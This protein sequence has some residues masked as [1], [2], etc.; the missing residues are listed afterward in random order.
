VAI[1]VGAAATASAAG[2]LYHNEAA[3]IAAFELPRG[4][5]QAA[6]VGY[7]RV[8]LVATGPEG[9]QLVLS[10]QPV[11][12]GTGAVVLAQRAAAALTAQGFASPRVVPDESERARL[13]ATLDG[14]RRVLRQLYAV[15]GDQAVVVTLVA[16][17]GQTAVLRAFERS[18]ETLEIG[19]PD[20]R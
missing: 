10:S 15:D 13:E 20:A 4:F 2:R 16:P 14:G 17:V 1:L 7:P 9:S 8:L 18:L 6:Q 11:A 19:A 12:S 5:Q 3:R